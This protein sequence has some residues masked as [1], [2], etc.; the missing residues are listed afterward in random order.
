M[1]AE[2]MPDLSTFG[3]TDLFFLYRAIL[4]E[5]KSR[6][7][8]RTENA[9]VGDYAEYLVVTALGGQLAPNSEKSWD[10]LSSDG[11]KLQVKARVG[12]I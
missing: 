10:V 4:S 11:E 7:V 1:P 5:L 2:N 12:L 9:P 6:G 8:I 3:E